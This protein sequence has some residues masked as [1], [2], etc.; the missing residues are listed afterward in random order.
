MARRFVTK[1]VKKDDIVSHDATH[2]IFMNNPDVY[3]DLL[4][5]K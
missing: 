2:L 5:P 4:V 3:S 1:L